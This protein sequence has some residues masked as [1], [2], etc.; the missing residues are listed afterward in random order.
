MRRIDSR[1]DTNS[2]EFQRYRA[3]NRKLVSGFQKAQE[4]ARF[5]RPQR[6]IERLQKQN[7]MMPRERLELL[8][9]PGTPFLEFSSLAGNMAYDGSA[10]SASCITG[11]GIVGGREVVINASDSSV[12]GGAWYPLS[13][14]KIIRALD[15]AIENHLPVIHMC[16][17]AG[18]FL[19]L[20][21][22][23]F[24]D[25]YMAGRIFRNQ[26]QLFQDGMQAAI[27]GIWA[28]YGRWSLYSGTFRLLGH[29]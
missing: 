20:Q 16:D 6:D 11:I 22:E 3:H 10:H 5:K 7:K 12:K 25:K 23:L 17:S 13:V 19:P 27:T 8:L 29:C 4:E 2:E 28:L 15:I 18:G 14:K 1:L 24:G 26:T 9:D 21:S